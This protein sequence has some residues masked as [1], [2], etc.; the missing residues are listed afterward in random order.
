[1]NEFTK[2]T[3]KMRKDFLV[4]YRKISVKQISQWV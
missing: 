2:H 4:K 1:M 3:K